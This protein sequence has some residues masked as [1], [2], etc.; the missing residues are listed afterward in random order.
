MSQFQAGQTVEVVGS[1]A[2]GTPGGRY[3]VI[4][5]LPMTHGMVRYRVKG[6]KEAFE[7]VIEER[8]MTPLPI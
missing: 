1:R 3:R 2:S 4:C 7:R 8:L 5:A 6:E